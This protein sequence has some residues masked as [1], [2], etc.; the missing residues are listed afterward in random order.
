[1]GPA[2]SVDSASTAVEASQMMMKHYRS[3]VLVENN[4]TV[5][6]IITMRDFMRVVTKE[7]T[8]PAEI[9]VYQLMSRP[10]IT[11]DSTSTLL[12]AAR[13]MSEK[14]IQNLPVL[15]SDRYVGIISSIDIVK[16]AIGETPV[17]GTPTKE[18]ALGEQDR[19]V[20][21]LNARQS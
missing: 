19:N 5:M 18:S 10:V 6:G 16:A 2:I 7:R 9:K 13:I 8:S 14:K 15:E 11:V 20:L 21:R 12:D 1:M 17:H 3:S 4:Q